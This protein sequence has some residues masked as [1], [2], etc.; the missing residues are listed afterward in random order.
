M[1][2]VLLVNENITRLVVTG[3]SGTVFHVRRQTL[4]TDELLRNGSVADGQRDT[5]N[6]LVPGTVAPNEN[7]VPYSKKIDTAVTVYQ[8]GSVT[9]FTVWYDI[10]S[11]TKLCTIV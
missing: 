5:E 2:A 3:R 8:S 10:I 4:T 7:S 11:R 9:G 1:C 6:R